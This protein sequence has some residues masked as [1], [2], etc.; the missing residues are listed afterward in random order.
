MEE[1]AIWQSQ[2]IMRLAAIVQEQLELAPQLRR[3]EEPKIVQAQMPV[4]E[5]VNLHVFREAGRKT[6][7]TAYLSKIIYYAVFYKNFPGKRNTF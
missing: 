2:I 4:E 7:I 6:P 1:G 5:P 3:K